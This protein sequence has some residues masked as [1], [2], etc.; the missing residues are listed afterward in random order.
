[1]TADNPKEIVD[2]FITRFNLVVRGEPVDP[3]GWLQM[4]D[5]NVNYV[6]QGL[7][8]IVA[9]CRSRAEAREK[10][11]PPEL[12]RYIKP[13]AGFGIYPLE[14]IQEGNRMVVIA[15]GRGGNIYGV[16]YNNTYFFFFEVVNGKIVRVV[17]DLDASITLRSLCNTHLVEGLRPQQ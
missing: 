4:L 15:K 10:L 5:D 8:P 9:R 11:F 17:E 12:S 2:E 13:T 6:R 7:E 14:Y 3:L 1:M 16:P